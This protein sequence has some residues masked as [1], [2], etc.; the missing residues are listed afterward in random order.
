M[1]MQVCMTW[2]SWLIS[3]QDASLG[4]DADKI[5]TQEDA[6]KVLNAEIRS[7]P[8][9][10]AQPGGVAAALRVAADLNDN[11]GLMVFPYEATPAPDE[12][13]T[14]ISPAT[15]NHVQTGVGNVH[16]KVE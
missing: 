7:S 10:E 4:L 12:E 1:Y 11:A 16:A 9:G 6:A 15:E 2:W 14:V 5:A 3:M 13:H 8:M